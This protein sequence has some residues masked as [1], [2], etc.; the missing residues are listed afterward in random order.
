MNRLFSI[1][2]KIRTVITISLVDIGSRWGI[3][4]P[5]NRV[6]LS[7]LRYYGF[8]A[9][10]EECRRLNSR[11]GSESIKYFPLAL[12]DREAS[13]KLFLTK[14]EGCSSIYPP[15]LK[16]INRYHYYDNWDIKGEIPI[17]TNKLDDVLATNRIAPDFLK[18]DTQGAELKIL[19]GADSLLGSILGLELEVEF[20]QLY[21]DQPLFADVDRYVRSHGFELYD[22]NRYW[23]N[24]RI[25][26][27]HTSNRGQL[28]F[29]DAIYFKSIDSFYSIP[30]KTENDKKEKLLK[31]VCILSLYGFFDFAIEYLSDTR[32]P[33]TGEEKKILKGTLIE[34]SSYPKWNRVL[35]NNRI[36]NKIG[37]LFYHLANLFSYKTK[38]YG[39]GTDYNA[40][41]GRYMYYH[42]SKLGDC[43]KS[44]RNML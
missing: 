35:L 8:D 24:N 19:K 15:D 3:Q 17:V 34:R 4:R 42:S 25:S 12:S 18:I 27:K 10:A 9:D 11:C 30:F 33:L 39:W 43:L 26:G 41:D 44:S 36:A 1:I 2:S 29:G 31:I 28:V 32:S 38:T 40:V 20:V 16:N 13:E 23:A 6:P 7:N 37:R 5:W 22:I 14:E 21:K